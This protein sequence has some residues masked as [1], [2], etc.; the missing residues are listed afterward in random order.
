M[1]HLFEKLSEA[2]FY[3]K[4]NYRGWRASEAQGFEMSVNH[5]ISALEAHA[6]VH[7]IAGFCDGSLI[8]AAVATRATSLQFFVNFC[9]GPASRLLP[10]DEHLHLR[11]KIPSI[12]FIGRADEM[13]STQE[14]MELP[15]RCDHAVIVRHQFGHVVPPLGPI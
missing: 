8:A 5:V 2:G 1:P 13:F 14:L 12:H 7:G 9:G 4:N 6:P 10:K 15:E 11:V 3:E